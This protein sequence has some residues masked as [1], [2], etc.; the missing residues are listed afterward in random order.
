MR[1]LVDENCSSREFVAL[2]RAAGH[3][4][5]TV[6]ASVGSGARDEAV[7]TYALRA[8][9]AIVT[10]DVEDFRALLVGRH[11]SGLLLIYEGEDGA[12]LSA[13]NLALMVANANATYASVVGMVLNLIEFLW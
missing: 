8:D 13:A 6:A 5:E 10:K 4:V 2:L 11:H 7:A 9:R 1:L 3:D 12:R